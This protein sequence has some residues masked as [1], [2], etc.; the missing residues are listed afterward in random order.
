[1]TDRHDGLGRALAKRLGQEKIP[2]VD[3]THKAGASSL[4]NPTRMKIFL[5]LCSSPGMGLRSLGRQ[6]GI[7][8]ATMKRHVDTMERKGLTASLAHRHRRLLYAPAVTTKE[9][10]KTLFAFNEPHL[11]S[12]YAKMGT[13]YTR[14]TKIANMNGEQPQTTHPRLRVL[15]AMGLVEE[16]NHLY[17]ATRIE[18]N[19]RADIETRRAN[20]VKNLK[21]ILE[22]ENLAPSN[23]KQYKDRLVA[24]VTLGKV[25]KNITIYIIPQ[26]LP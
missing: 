25:R 6:T 19:I 10:C 20:T 26:N 4:M 21:H 8:P 5:T 18:Q 2:K 23:F 22:E 9:E 13:G 14:L 1:M 15:M 3:E 11:K 17:R 16:K 12:I 24:T 7:D